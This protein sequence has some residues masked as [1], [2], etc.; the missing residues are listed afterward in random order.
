LLDTAELTY[1]SITTANISLLKTGG[2]STAQRAALGAARIS[3]LA[4]DLDADG[5]ETLSIDEG[6]HF[7]LLGEGRNARVGWIAPDDGL[8]ALDR[9]RNGSIDSGRELFGEGTS[10]AGASFADGFQALASIDTNRDGIINWEDVSFPDLM[11]WR[12]LNRDGKSQPSELG[13]LAAWGIDNLSLAHVAS[14]E[15]Q[16]G[17]LLGL[18]GEYTLQDGR[19]LPLVDVW[20][21]IEEVREEVKRQQLQ[22]FGVP[23]VAPADPGG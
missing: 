1:L 9:D 11:I 20:L 23:P 17:N 8:L 16:H 6:V 4:L 12:D 21:Q 2:L 22:V 13:S 14:N 10:S 19:K 3:P 7:D 5:I 15:V 18:I